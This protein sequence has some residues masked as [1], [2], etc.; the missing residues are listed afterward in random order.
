ME[1]LDRLE[2]LWAVLLNTDDVFP[3]LL[4]V[5]R[6]HDSCEVRV[7]VFLFQ[8]IEGVEERDAVELVELG[9]RKLINQGLDA[10]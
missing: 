1:V 6:E 7:D 5:V 2:D 4:S 3:E 8:G 10:G 9:K